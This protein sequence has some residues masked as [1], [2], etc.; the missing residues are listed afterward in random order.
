MGLRFGMTSFV[1]SIEKLCWRIW[2]IFEPCLS[3][4]A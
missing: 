1:W 4:V 3:L 2:C